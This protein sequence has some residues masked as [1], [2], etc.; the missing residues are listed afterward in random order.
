MN[1]LIVLGVVCYLL[2]SQYTEKIVKAK[3][4]IILP[5]ILIFIGYTDVR[6]LI[7]ASDIAIFILIILCAVF[8]II[9]FI[10][11]GFIKFYRKSDGILYQKGGII[12]IVFLIMGIVL[13]EGAIDFLKHTQY[14]ILAQGS[15][16][17]ILL[18]GF[19][20]A[21]RSI[22]VI[23]REPSIWSQY[24]ASRNKSKR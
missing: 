7:K 21:G 14:S 19:Q 20:F 22:R 13:K 11:G 18:L 15:L 4:Y 23:H 1:Y 6:G 5:I 10:S 2:Y 12:S 9:G 24:I 17:L 16:L 8:L 3:Q